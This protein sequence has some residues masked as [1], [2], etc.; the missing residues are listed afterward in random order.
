MADQATTTTQS[1]A[2]AEGGA[3]PAPE[4]T[5][6]GGAQAG[7]ATASGDQGGSTD[8]GTGADSVGGDTSGGD[9]QPGGEESQPGADSLS[10]DSYS[11]MKLPDGFEADDALIGDAKQ[12]MLDA[13]VPPDQ[14]QKFLDLYAKGLQT[15]TDKLVQSFQTQ[16]QQWRD[17]IGQWPE[18]KGQDATKNS[19]AIIGQVIDQFGSEDVRKIMDSTGAGN[20]PALVRMFLNIG[21]AMAEGKSTPPGG[22][23]KGTGPKTLGQTFF[24][25]G[26]SNQQ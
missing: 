16:Q 13:K 2:P 19:T 9:S 7:D 18:F 8:S 4:S 23:A 11:S 12:L 22:P 1:A 21:K 10:L 25:E 17:E 14:A 3:P 5:L 24:P 20:H 15:Q 6:L 26:D